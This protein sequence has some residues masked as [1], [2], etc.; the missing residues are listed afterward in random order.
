M[1]ETQILSTLPGDRAATAFTARSSVPAGRALVFDAC[2]AGVVLR[3]VMFVEVVL[4]V[5]VLYG[6]ENLSDWP[7]RR[8]WPC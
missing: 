2:H 7:P 3:A 6:A 5:G 1:Q 8:R 4:A